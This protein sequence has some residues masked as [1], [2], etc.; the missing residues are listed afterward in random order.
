M[1]TRAMSAVSGSL[2][3]WA[4]AVAWSFQGDRSASVAVGALAIG[5]LGTAIAIAGSNRPAPSRARILGAVA[6]GAVVA[7]ALAFVVNR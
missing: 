4:L 6:A 2:I 3:M 1:S 7:A 5:V